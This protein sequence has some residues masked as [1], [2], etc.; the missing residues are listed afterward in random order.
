MYKI[1]F[2]N[3]KYLQMQSKKILDRANKFEDKLYLEFGGKFF[4]DLHA[5][6]VLPGF[7]P[8]SQIR[9]LKT[10]ADQ[11][12]IVLVIKATDIEQNRIQGDQGI[13]YGDDLLRLINKMKS[14]GLYVSSV[15]VT[16][17]SGQDSADVFRKR[18]EQLGVAV[19]THY[20]IN[21]Y[22]TNISLI[23]S[24]EGF[25]KNDY[26]QTSRSIVVVGASGSS[27]GKMTTCLS[28]LYHESVRG[29]KAG[30]AKFEK[31]P[32]WNIPLSHPINLAYE[33]ATTDISDMNMIDPFHLEAYG[34]SA[35]NY[36]RDIEVFP[37]LCEIF[38]KIWGDSPYK[39]PT[40]MGVNMFGECIVDDEAC[41]Y[42]SKQEIIR[43][44]YIALCKDWMFGGMKSEI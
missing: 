13:T 9:L 22:P 11:T 6:R 31:F 3:H 10:I 26:I 2:D 12:E 24:D 16:M 32:I 20:F 36:N 33:A 25:G 43:R 39:S 15:V 29:I 27:S 4:D 19:Y 34:I 5:S 23:M 1:G 18:I 41:Q 8:N 7:E 28:Q 35:I 14:H 17:Y 40:D 30:Y 42:A 37:I 38:K 44:Y 21:D